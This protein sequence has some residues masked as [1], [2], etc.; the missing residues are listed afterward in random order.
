MT[1]GVPPRIG[2]GSN[3]FPGRLAHMPRKGR[4]RCG[5]LFH[6]RAV[7]KPKL[8][9]HPADGISIAFVSGSTRPLPRK[10]VSDSA[11]RSCR[12]MGRYG[13]ILASPSCG[14]WWKT[15]LP[16]SWPLPSTASQSR[17][18]RQGRSWYSTP[19]EV[20]AAVVADRTRS[21]CRT[22]VGTR[23]TR[24]RGGRVRACRPSRKGK[25]PRRYRDIAP[26]STTCCRTPIAPTSSGSVGCDSGRPLRTAVVDVNGLPLQ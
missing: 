21:P 9:P 16:M 20:A 3:V 12:A 4:V 18:N 15:A 10:P 24:S 23:L 22:S 25:W 7:G 26:G 1:G 5:A 2:L 8:G 14:Y 6:D 13:S 19:R 11:R 17:R